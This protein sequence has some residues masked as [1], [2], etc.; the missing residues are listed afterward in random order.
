MQNYSLFKRKV[1]HQAKNSNG[2]TIKRTSSRWNVHFKNNLT[3]KYGNSISV[4]SLSKKLGE[5]SPA[6]MTKPMARNIV[7]R[8]LESGLIENTGKLKTDILLSEYLLNFWDFDNSEY[9]QISNKL[10]P[11]SIGR[12]TASR[13]LQNLKLHVLKSEKN[14]KGP[15]GKAIGYYLPEGLLASQLT[16][17][18]IE[19]LQKSVLVTKGLSAKSWLNITC[20]LGPAFNEL[21]RTGKMI[22]NPLTQVRRPSYDSTKSSNRG[23]TSVEANAIFLKAIYMMDEGK[24]DKR[25]CLGILLAGASGMRES[26]IRALKEENVVINEFSDYAIVYVEE[27]I[28]RLDGLKLPKGKKTRIT[29]IPKDLGKA[30]KRIAGDSGFVFEG[31]KAGQ[32][33]S[34]DR[35]RVALNSVLEELDIPKE[36]K[37]GKANFHSLRH[38]ANSEFFLR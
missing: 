21:V 14:T 19:L 20:A 36:T 23:F 1:E 18:H 15:N 8:A 32:P 31:Q 27:T 3:G 10:K 28:A 33:I 35:L 34:E 13:N 11:N 4:E 38:F 9:V 37:E 26:E 16:R 30:L 2:E 5:P 29:Y 24:L 17:D 7:E 22:A 12:Y 6:N 25:Y